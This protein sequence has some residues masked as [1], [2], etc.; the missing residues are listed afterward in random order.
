MQNYLC[1]SYICIGGNHDG[2]DYPAYASAETVQLPVGVIG[3]ETY[4]RDSMSIGD[5]AVTIFRH[6]SL[7]RTQVIALLIKHYRAW[8]V[9]RPGG[10]R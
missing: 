9:Y 7:T 4:I 8:C 2:L 3:K 1:E 6:E 10:R 5:E